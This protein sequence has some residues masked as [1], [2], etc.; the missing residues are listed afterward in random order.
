MIL[1]TSFFPA[2]G[3][4]L[5]GR[6]SRQRRVKKMWVWLGAL[7]MELAAQQGISII[8][9]A[10]NEEANIAQAVAQAMQCGS[11]LFQDWEIIIVNDGSRDHTGQIIDRLAEQNATV[12]AL[13][14]PSNQ[15]YGAALR[16]GIQRA[17]KELI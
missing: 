8:F 13:H 10:Y 14:H 6:Y 1:L 5:H 15:G 11:R 12:T 4:G 9:P 17:R 7:P 2:S 16:T 3:K